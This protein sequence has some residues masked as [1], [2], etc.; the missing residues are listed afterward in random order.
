M[1]SETIFKIL[2]TQNFQFYM[3]GEEDESDGVG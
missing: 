3:E 2:Q 1:S